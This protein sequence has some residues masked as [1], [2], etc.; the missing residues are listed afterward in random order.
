MQLNELPRYDATDNETNCCPRFHPEPWDDQELHFKDKPFVRASTVSL[1][2]VPLNMGSIFG[3]TYHAIEA[4]HAQG[5]SF[6]VLSHD[7]SP[8][9]A[10]HLFAVAGP[11]PGAEM[12][13][14]TGDYMTKV[15]DGPF[16]QA[17]GWC[18][19]M[20]QFV[21]SKG[22]HLDTQYF[23]FTTCPKCAKHYGKNYVVGIAKVQ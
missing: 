19:E 3:R 12:V 7:D 18:D 9:H 15:F 10:E 1:F 13:N 16:S 8:W 4:A 5:G 17:R 20:R 21:E 14:L 2:H 22:K 6:L 23:F 11:V